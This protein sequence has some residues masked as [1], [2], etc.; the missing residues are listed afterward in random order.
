[1]VPAEGFLAA[2][3]EHSKNMHFQTGIEMEMTR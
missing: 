3:M 1:M 2:L